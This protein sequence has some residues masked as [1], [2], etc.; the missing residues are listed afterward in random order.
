MCIHVDKI[1]APLDGSS[2]TSVSRT[3]S[4]RTNGNVYSATFNCTIHPDSDVEFCSVMLAARESKYNSKHCQ[5]VKIYYIQYLFCVLYVYNN[6][7][8]M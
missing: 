8:N 3:A 6:S 7:F 5:G 2:V 4:N 1:F